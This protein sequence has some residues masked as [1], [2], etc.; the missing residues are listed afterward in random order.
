[1]YI[2]A[3]G[4]ERDHCI[5]G[6]EEIGERGTSRCGLRVD[7]DLTEGIADTNGI[8]IAPRDRGV[9]NDL[10][11]EGVEKGI[12]SGGIHEVRSAGG[13]RETRINTVIAALLLITMG[14]RATTTPALLRTCFN[15]PLIS[16]EAFLVTKWAGYQNALRL[17]K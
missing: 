11:V 7:A 9:V 13:T 14:A 10:F 17:G 12:L 4:L 3:L 5:E 8:G 16:L 2:C 6:P 1:M 15:R